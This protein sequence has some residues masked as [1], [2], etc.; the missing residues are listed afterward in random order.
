MGTEFFIAIGVFLQN[1]QPAKFQCS[2]LQIGQDSPIQ[3]SLQCRR[4]VGAIELA[5]SQRY[6]L[7]TAI[8][9]NVRRWG[10][11]EGKN[12]KNEIFFAP[13]PPLFLLLPITHPLG[14]TFFLSPVFPCVK[15]S[16]WQLN[17]S[18]CQRSLE[19]IS[20]ALQATFRC[21]IYTSSNHRLGSAGLNALEELLFRCCQQRRW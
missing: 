11:G 7:A 18:R 10:M 15:N 3:V 2:A 19:E 14:R 16:I 13:P 20:P 21:L 12:E 5:L 17:F 1:Y 4:L 6:N 9:R 8:R